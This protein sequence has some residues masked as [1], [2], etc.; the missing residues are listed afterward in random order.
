VFPWQL[1]PQGH[2]PRR[3]AHISSSGHGQT[4]WQFDLRNAESYKL[5]H[6][7]THLSGR[8]THPRSTFPKFDTHEQLGALGMFYY[9]EALS[10]QRAARCIGATGV[11]LERVASGGFRETWSHCTHAHAWKC[12][13]HARVAKSVAKGRSHRGACL[14]CGKRIQTSSGTRTKRCAEAALN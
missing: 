7:S 9:Y 2:R 6:K 11:H 14:I 1:A 4:L 5:F 3:I 12:Q 13:A 10:E 8:P